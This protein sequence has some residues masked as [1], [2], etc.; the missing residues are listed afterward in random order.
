[1]KVLLVI[2]IAAV[3]GIVVLNFSTSTAHAERDQITHVIS[4]DASA[5]CV[6][7]FDVDDL[8]NDELYASM[9]NIVGGDSYHSQVHMSH[10]A[11]NEPKCYVVKRWRERECWWEPGE[12]GSRVRVCTP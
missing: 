1:M 9:A 7:T 10:S 5:D 11:S 3:A 2:A 8:A 4:A 6:T 12:N